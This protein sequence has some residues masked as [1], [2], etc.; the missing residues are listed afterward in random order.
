[1]KHAFIHV[2]TKMFIDYLEKNQIINSDEYIT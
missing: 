2:Q 1:M